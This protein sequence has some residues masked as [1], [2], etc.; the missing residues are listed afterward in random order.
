[1]TAAE[2]EAIPI[3][4][5]IYAERAVVDGKPVTVARMTP[6]FVLWNEPDEPIFYLFRS[7]KWHVGK[8]KGVTYRKR[9]AT[10]WTG[11]GDRYREPVPV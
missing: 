9:V 8:C 5:E 10:Y 7:S 6:S 3:I 11:A 1:M 4:G 2:F